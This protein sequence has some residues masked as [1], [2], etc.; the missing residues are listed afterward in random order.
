MLMVP[1]TDFV[2]S[3]THL[4]RILPENGAQE[5]F[6]RPLGASRL[7]EHFGLARGL[8]FWR[9]SVDKLDSGRHFGP[10][11]V[12][13][14]SPSRVLGRHVKERKKRTTVCPTTGPNKHPRIVDVQ[15]VRM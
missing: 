2:R 9:H 6:G 10:S 5:H 1:L 12:T 15:T 8:S 4:V 11:L 13:K 3:L 14:G 7:Q